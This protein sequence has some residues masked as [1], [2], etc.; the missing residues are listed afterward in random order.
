MVTW[1]GN[2]KKKYCKA[3]IKYEDIATLQRSSRSLSRRQHIFW[4]VTRFVKV[5]STRNNASDLA[6]RLIFWI[7]TFFVLLEKILDA[8]QPRYQPIFHRFRALDHLFATLGVASSRLKYISHAQLK[9]FSSVRRITRR[10]S[11][12]S[13]LKYNGDVHSDLR[14]FGRTKLSSTF[15]NL[16]VLSKSGVVWVIESMTSTKSSPWNTL[17]N[18]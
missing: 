18:R 12:G 10:A 17:E 6:S 16:M 5:F 9:I 1:A 15:W 14:S 8:F 3:H 11:L 13:N 7:Q 4:S 2:I